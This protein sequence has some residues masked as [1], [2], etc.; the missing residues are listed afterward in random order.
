MCKLFFVL[1]TVFKAQI[2]YTFKDRLEQGLATLVLECR[3]PA[4]FSSNPENTSP[5]CS[6]SNSEDLD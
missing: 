5:A 1:K 6:P 2:T 4:E 3:C